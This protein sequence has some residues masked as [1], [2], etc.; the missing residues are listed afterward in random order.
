ML[1][2]GPVSWT[3]RRQSVVA[4]STLE[5]EYIAL[6]QACREAAWL[7]KLVVELGVYKP[8][9]RIL[10][11]VDNMGAISTSNNPEQHERTKH[12]DIRYHYTREEVAAGRVKLAFV[13]SAD[14]VADGFTKPLPKPAHERFVS[15]LRLCENVGVAE[16]CRYKYEWRLHTTN[17]ST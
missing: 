13:R 9:Y 15:R 4:Q 2:R 14:N 11:R 12:F 16:E 7:R 10:I 3:S 6:S 1:N 8:D 17:G 5:A